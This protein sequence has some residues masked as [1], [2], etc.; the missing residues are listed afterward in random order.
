MKESVL[1][2][3]ARELV[4]P[5]NQSGRPVQPCD[6]RAGKYREGV[7]IASLR[8]LDELSLVHGTPL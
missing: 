8:S 7:M 2:R 4:V 6:E 3:V 1:D 5:E